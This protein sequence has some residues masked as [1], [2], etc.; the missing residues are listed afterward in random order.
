VNWLVE[1]TWERTLLIVALA[2]L[3]VIFS[4]VWL[5]IGKRWLIAL[6]AAC[7]VLIVAVLAAG[8]L[9]VTDREVVEAT[10]REIAAAVERNDVKTVVGHIHS[11][12][13]DIAATAESE[14]PRYDFEE[15]DIKSNLEIEV[16]S[17]GDPPTAVAKFNVVVR[18]KFRGG[19]DFSE[20]Y[21]DRG[22]PRYVIVKFQ[23]EGD[24]WKV[25]DYE[26]RDPFGHEE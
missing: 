19:G 26:H 1:A 5:R 12:R 8:H 23:K 14:L 20:V 13:T 4:L 2:A 16:D 9:I 6:A 15:V 24:V 11:Q 7:G 10:L 3:A 17:Q 22:V 25:I 21:G 18:G